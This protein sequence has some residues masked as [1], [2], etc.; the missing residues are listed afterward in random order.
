MDT[1]FAPTGKA[2]RRVPEGDPLNP[3]GRMLRQLEQ[4]M[5]DAVQSALTDL[6]AALFEGIDESN[7]LMVTMRLGQESVI[8][9]FRDRIT[10]IL[11]KVAI[12]GSES[13]R[14]QV[15]GQVFGVRL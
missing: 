1:P 9:P 5:I 15:E 4:E 8:I 13:G 6:Q 11:Q 7:I 2:T 3:D 14:E 10:R 12:V